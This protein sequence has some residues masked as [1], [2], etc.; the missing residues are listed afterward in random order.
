LLPRGVSRL[1]GDAAERMRGL[2][3]AE[4]VDVRSGDAAAVAAIA[5]AAR[6]AGRAGLPLRPLYLSPPLAR[7]PAGV[8]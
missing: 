4:I 8:S 5:A 2:V 1:A 7:T 3:A 6:E